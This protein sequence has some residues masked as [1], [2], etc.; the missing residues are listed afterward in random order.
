MARLRLTAGRRA[1]RQ[2]AAEEDVL[3]ICRRYRLAAPSDRDRVGEM[4]ESARRVN[5]LRCVA[6]A[7]QDSQTASS[8]DWL[9]A[10]PLSA[11]DR[12]RWRT[13]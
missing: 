4:V 1:G 10:W 2:R 6:I 7:L 9:A 13:R 5:A 12:D 11:R 3:V 8:N